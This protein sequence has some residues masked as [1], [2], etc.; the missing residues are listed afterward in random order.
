MN[1]VFQQVIDSEVGDCTNACIATVTGIPISELPDSG[2]SKPRDDYYERLQEVL[3]LNSWVYFETEKLDWW[4][5]WSA[6]S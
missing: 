6:L 4:W 2:V 1:K 3:S 5:L